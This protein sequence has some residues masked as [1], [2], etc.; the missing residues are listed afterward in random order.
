MSACWLLG[1]KASAGRA[2]LGISGV[3]VCSGSYIMAILE[4]KQHIYKQYE[5]EIFFCEIEPTEK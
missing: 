4:T 2:L 3:N 5:D 1:H